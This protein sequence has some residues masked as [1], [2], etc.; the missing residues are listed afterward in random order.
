MLIVAAR[1][2]GA[3]VLTSYGHSRRTTLSESLLF[4]RMEDGPLQC[5]LVA[6]VHLSR[7]RRKQMLI[8]GDYRATQ[9]KM[10]LFETS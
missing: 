5:C 8:K 3:V 7:K 10:D 9:Q 1:L 6:S 4:D 2:T